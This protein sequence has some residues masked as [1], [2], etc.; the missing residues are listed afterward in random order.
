MKKLLLLAIMVV[1]TVTAMAQ[2]GRYR[3]PSPTSRV[4]MLCRW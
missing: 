1:T 3:V 2:T 4:K